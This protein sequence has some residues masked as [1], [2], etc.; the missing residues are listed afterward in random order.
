MINSIR[1]KSLLLLL[2]IAFNG[3]MKAQE[4]LIPVAGNPVARDY[5]RNHPATRKAALADTVELPFIDD[6]SDSYVQPK[7]TLW[8]DW[9]AFI[10]NTYPVFPVTA[11]VATLDAYNYDGSE[12]PD[13]S[14][15]ALCCRPPYVQA[16]QSELSGRRQYLSEL[17]FPAKRHCRNAGSKGFH[18]P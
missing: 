11:G 7:S 16:R 5:Y 1:L 10:N 2:F 13:V 6:F 9:F 18:L 4:I 17:L 8:S 3:L 12:Y 14:A 15:T